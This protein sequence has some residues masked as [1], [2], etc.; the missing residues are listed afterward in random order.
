M[1]ALEYGIFATGVTTYQVI[2]ID[3]SELR[4]QHDGSNER[5]YR[6]KRVE[7]QRDDREGDGGD[8]VRGEAVEHGEPAEG[9]HEHGEVERRVRD[10]PAIGRDDVADQRGREK[11]PEELDEAENRLDELHVE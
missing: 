6:G 5:K 4:G 1:W 11:H 7:C 10:V 2:A 9:A 8:E 3:G